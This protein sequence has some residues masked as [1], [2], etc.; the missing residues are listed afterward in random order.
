MNKLLKSILIGVMA[1]FVFVGCANS[2]TNENQQETNNTSTQN[3]EIVTE[4]QTETLESETDV[5]ESELPE[6]SEIHSELEEVESETISKNEPTEETP[7]CN[8]NYSEATC[9]EPAKCKFCGLV[10]GNAL[11]HDVKNADCTNESKCKRCGKKIG[12]ANGHDYIDATCTT[13][14][15]CSVCGTTKGNALGHNYSNATCTEASK[16][17]NCGNTKGKALGHSYS[18]ATCTE[19]AKC[20]T[21]GLTKG[22]ALGHTE[23]IDVAVEATTSSTGLTEGK[24]CSVCGTILVAQEE[25]PK[26]TIEKFYASNIGI[27]FDNVKNYSSD[28]WF[29]CGYNVISYNCNPTRE[30]VYIDYNLSSAEETRVYFEIKVK[31][32]TTCAGTAIK[33]PYTITNSAGEVVAN[34]TIS[35]YRGSTDS[36]FSSG[37]TVTITKSIY[38]SAIADNYTIK[39]TK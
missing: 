3:S 7:K 36:P 13:P 10:K 1:I 30:Y 22:S 39:F 27:T 33:I 28:D 11:G 18:N 25:I 17:S 14:A 29:D 31:V 34:G 23:V 16:C 8:H 15:K 19:P 32:K 24:H 26:I 4:E 6:N 21:C 35:E 38:F 12:G 2:E 9:T 5:V 37:T 20:N